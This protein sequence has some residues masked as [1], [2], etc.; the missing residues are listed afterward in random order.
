LAEE[1]E[2][3]NNLGNPTYMGPRYRRITGNDRLL[4]KVGK[5]GV[6]EHYLKLIML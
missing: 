3:Q 4:E 6:Q 5:F 2:A 1:I